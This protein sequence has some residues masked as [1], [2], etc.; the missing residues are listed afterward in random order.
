MVGHGT[1]NITDTDYEELVV[2]RWPRS[3]FRS[4]DNQDGPVRPDRDL[5]SRFM[6]R[7]VA[8]LMMGWVNGYGFHR[9]YR[10]L[11]RIQMELAAYENTGNKE[12]LVNLANYAYLEFH[13]PEREGAYY[14]PGV[15]SVTRGKV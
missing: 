7:M 4:P 6:D 2:V 9:R 12:H 10:Y 14:D 13:K 11:T 3:S 1:T 15:E 8:R 5:F